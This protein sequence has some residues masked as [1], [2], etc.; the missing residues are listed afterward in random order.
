MQQAWSCICCNTMTCTHTAVNT[1]SVGQA[2]AQK[3][4]HL[5]STGLLSCTDQMA[6]LWM[7]AWLHVIHCVKAISADQS[8]LNRVEHCYSV[9]PL[10]PGTNFCAST[11]HVLG[12]NAAQHVRRYPKVSGSSS[13][14]QDAKYALPGRVVPPNR[15]H[16]FFLLRN[17]QRTAVH[18]YTNITNWWLLFFVN[19]A[20][21]RSFGTE[22]W[23]QT[24]H[25][26]STHN[27]QSMVFVYAA[28]DLDLHQPQNST[29]ET[30]ALQTVNLTKWKKQASCTDS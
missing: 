19:T 26:S 2:T 1:S 30:T 24:K 17:L 9:A 4:R 18:V 25:K 12:Y 21:I 22:V 5:C 15:Q 8:W 13:C 20:S 3:L 10:S 11:C 16:V 23:M 27:Y 28:H 7:S 6:C 29:T 14:I